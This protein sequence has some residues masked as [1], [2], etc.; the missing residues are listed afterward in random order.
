MQNC[1]QSGGCRGSDIEW[2]KNALQNNDNVINY[3]S[4]I[5]QNNPYVN[6]FLL[7][8][9]EELKLYDTYLLKANKTLQ[10]SFPTNKSY[11]NNILRRNY[12]QIQYSDLLYAIGFLDENGNVGGGT[13]WT[14]QLFYE[15]RIMK[16]DNVERPV[17]FYCQVRNKWYKLKNKVNPN[18]KTKTFDEK[19][20]QIDRPSKPFGIYT[21]IGTRDI[22]EK[23]KEEIKLVYSS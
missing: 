6:T 3:V 4:R 19:W 12:C 20:I 15:N 23:G 5:S 1:L 11:I 16:N 2:T 13:G 9:E 8:K 18:L 17:Y 14:V 7:V 21:G 10:R 22:K